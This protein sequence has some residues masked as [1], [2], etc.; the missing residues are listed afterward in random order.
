MECI[1]LNAINVYVY[2]GVYHGNKVIVIV[3]EIIQKFDT[4]YEI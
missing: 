3:Y 1:A 4:C 2:T